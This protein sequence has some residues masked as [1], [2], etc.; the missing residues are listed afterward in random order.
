MTETGLSTRLARTML[1]RFGSTPRR[2]ALTVFLLAAGLI[3][4]HERTCRCRH[5]LPGCG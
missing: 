4:L 2:L 5:A 3:V 1:V